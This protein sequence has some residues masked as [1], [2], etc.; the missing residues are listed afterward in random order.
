MR[1]TLTL[2]EDVATKARMLAKKLD[3]PFKQ[4]INTALRQGLELME[5]PGEQRP[6]VTQPR[7]M[8][9]RPGLSLDNIQELLAQVEGEEH[10]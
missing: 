6:Y 3:R 2:D 7:A 4:V 9:L 8:G 5:H 1:T 10:K